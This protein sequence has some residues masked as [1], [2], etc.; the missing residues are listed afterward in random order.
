MVN[1]RTPGARNE[2]IL[3]VLLIRLSQVVDIRRGIEQVFDIRG[4]IGEPE[5]PVPNDVRTSKRQVH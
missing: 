5:T 3:R 1:F 2:S 4:R